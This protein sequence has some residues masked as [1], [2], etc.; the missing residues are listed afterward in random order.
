VHAFIKFAQMKH[1]FVYDPIAIIK[2]LKGD[3]YNMY[4]DPNS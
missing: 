4:C 1:I 2:V 3:I